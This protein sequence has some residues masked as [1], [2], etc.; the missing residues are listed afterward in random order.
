MAPAQDHDFS[1]ITP[2]INTSA[3]SHGK[4]RPEQ[5]QKISEIIGAAGLNNVVEFMP[6][7]NFSCDGE[8]SG[9][10][11]IVK[12]D[13]P[14]HAVFGDGYRIRA[15]YPLNKGNTT[16]EVLETGEQLGFSIGKTMSRQRINTA[17]PKTALPSFSSYPAHEF[18]ARTYGSI[19][20]VPQTLFEQLKGHMSAREA[21]TPV[22]SPSLD[23]C[24]KVATV[25]YYD[26]H[27]SQ[28]MHG[29]VVES[30]APHLANAV[31]EYA[32]EKK[33]TVKEAVDEG[34]F[35]M[36]RTMVNMNADALAHRTASALGLADKLAKE[37]KNDYTDY[38]VVTNPGAEKFALPSDRTVT[39]N[40]KAC[41]DGNGFIVFNNAID[42]T[43]SPYEVVFDEGLPKYKLMIP[44]SLDDHRMC[45]KDHLNSEKKLYSWQNDAHNTF[46][47]SVQH[48]GTFCDTMT[49][50][51]TKVQDAYA[52]KLAWTNDDD[53]HFHRGVQAPVKPANNSAEYAA[54]MG[55]NHGW[56]ALTM[57]VGMAKVAPDCG[58]NV[59]MDDVILHGQNSPSNFFYV[60]DLEEKLRTGAKDVTTAPDYV[61]VPSSSEIIAQI[62]EAYPDLCAQWT[63]DKVKVHP[64]STL[65]GQQVG[66]NI[67]VTHDTINMVRNVQDKKKREVTDGVHDVVKL[68]MRRVAALE[69]AKAK[70]KC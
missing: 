39:H 13:T 59:T 28:N 64:L 21:E 47:A 42:L 32:K 66:N 31:V 5:L 45:T 49:K 63:K 2:L 35:G 62:A 20:V 27:S 67:K 51:N 18:V 68:T 65:I 46:P 10:V 58:K 52:T 33:L 37:N 14:A 30:G 61:T 56:T 22:W 17:L 4:L 54:K 34:P 50:S 69:E 40:I 26:N 11:M 9:Y 16:Q 55:W 19:G 7:E 53:A 15:F 48:S 23:S 12:P 60:P 8:G 41:K 44:R 3:L 57:D 36:F 1:Q 38:S 70:A 25:Q 29:L 43:E 6:H 24:G